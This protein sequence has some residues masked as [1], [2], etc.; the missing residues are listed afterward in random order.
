MKLPWNRLRRTAKPSEEEKWTDIPKRSEWRLTAC[1]KCKR[2]AW[3]GVP[4]P[5]VVT[6]EEP[7]EQ[8]VRVNQGRGSSKRVTVTAPLRVVR[9]VMK[10]YRCPA[11]GNDQVKAATTAEHILALTMLE[12]RRA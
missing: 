10:K 1:D 11:C 2:V 8:L 6:S 9:G 3:A 7:V 5:H 4:I 12:R